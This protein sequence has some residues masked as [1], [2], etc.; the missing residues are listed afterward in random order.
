MSEYFIK[1]A[2]SGLIIAGTVL[3]YW[4]SGVINEYEA[5]EQRKR[6]ENPD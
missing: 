1:A 3:F 5:R 4:L 6:E 2:Y